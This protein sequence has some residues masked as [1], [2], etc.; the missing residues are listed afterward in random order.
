MNKPFLINILLSSCLIINS[1]NAQELIYNKS[2]TGVCYAGNKTTRIYI[3]PPQRFLKNDRSKG[4]G[5]I[6][7]YYT[8]YS[9]EAMEAFEYAVSILEVL[10]PAD[11]KTTVLTSWVRI[12]TSGVLANS[13][14]TAI[15]GGWAI[16]ALNPLAL[17][18]VSLAEKIAGRSLNSD[19]EGDITLAVNSSVNWYLGTDGNVPVGKYDFVTVVLHE[20]CHGLGFFDSFNTDSNTGWYGFS[21]FPVIYDTFIENSQGKLLTDTLEFRNYTMA[22]R[23]ELTGGNLYFRGP[24]F[25]KLTGVPK[26]RIY[27]PATWDNGSSISHLDEELTLQPNELMTP[28]IDM[29]EAIHDPGIYTLSVLG[30]IGWINTRIIHE[31]PGDSEETLSQIEL[32]VEI[33]SDTIFNRDKVALVY[34]FDSFENSDT[35]FM[36]SFTSDNHFS[37]NVNLPSYNTELQYYFF[38]E[39]F[40]LRS[41]HSPSLY[42]LFR[43]KAFIGSDTIKPDLNHTPAEYYFETVDSITLMAE[44]DDNIGIDSVYL[45][46]WVDDNQSAF[47]SFKYDK[48]DSYKIVLGTEDL[49]LRGGDSLRY[50]IFA[51]DSAVVPNISVAPDSGYYSIGI[52]NIGPVISSYTSDFTD[53]EDDFFKLGFEFT[54]PLGFQKS[55]LHS[56][57]PYESPE[58]NG[59]NLNFIAMLLNPLKLDESGLLFQYSDIALIEPGEDGAAFGSVDFYDYVVVEASKDFGKSWLSL[60]D[61]YDARFNSTWLK[62][63]N[64]SIVDQNSTATAKEWMFVKQSGFISPS[65]S[66]KAGDTILIRFRLFSDPFAYGWGWAIQDLEISPLIDGIEE[67]MSE[68]L[69]I[70]PNP[71]RGI[72]RLKGQGIISGIYPVRYEVFNTTGIPVSK[73]FASVGNETVIDITG[74]SS[75]IYIIVIYFDDGI[76]TFKYSLI[77]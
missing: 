57:H 64:S 33:K 19:L 4:G 6:T 38:T 51:T 71:G 37:V 21:S 42:Q 44:A 9:T 56:K 29:R 25:E 18:P 75:G 74:L 69:M 1:I 15:A 50:R 11:T 36:T 41:F 13:S 67:L 22:L 30:D 45:E 31:P 40:F 16:D 48:D 24:V 76:R 46:Y 2:V 70:Y 60:F 14:V 52:V 55:G 10:L 5:S 34:S 3:P 20:L 28:L 66:L 68:K 39:D 7:V 77:K 63:Y 59:K 27:A 32:S 61:G 53:A 23:N 12:E 65:A 35:L 58:E 49:L 73:G 54:R 72:I 62:T 17:Y 43:Y 47:A 8:G 26:T